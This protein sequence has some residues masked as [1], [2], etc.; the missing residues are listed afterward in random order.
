MPL[1]LWPCV[2]SALHLLLI[3]V[4]TARNM[5]GML[6]SFSCQVKLLRSLIIELSAQAPT[7]SAEDYEQALA[8][9]RQAV[10]ILK[11]IGFMHNRDVARY[12]SQF[13]MVV[14][15]LLLNE[16]QGTSTTCS[17]ASSWDSLRCNKPR[18]NYEKSQKYSC[19]AHLDEKRNSCIQMDGHG[20]RMSG[21]DFLADA[22]LCHRA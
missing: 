6:R 1:Q 18:R 20:I 8:S 13:L 9:T 12:A 19:L 21:A 5:Y 14:P 11:A 10:A 22:C 17:A 4:L 3:L 2:D 15:E 16:P 7:E